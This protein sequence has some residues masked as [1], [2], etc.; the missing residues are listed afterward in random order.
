M[1]AP[2]FVDTNVLL[3]ARDASEPEKQPVAAAWLEA[4]WHD[5]TGRLSVQVLQE[6]YAVATRKFKPGLPRA[7]ARADIRN[8]VAWQP[9]AIDE[10]VLEMAWGV[11][12]RFGLSWWD[13]LI[14]A[15]AKRGGCRWL[16]T[17]DLQH[18]QDLDGVEVVSPFVVEP[19]ELD[20]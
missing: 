5:R 20:D 18:G 2:I 9:I 1:T 4:L 7:E 13:A 6:Y 16:L 17:E 8:L 10:G 19:G 15:A 3:Y 14:V 11:Q 12:D